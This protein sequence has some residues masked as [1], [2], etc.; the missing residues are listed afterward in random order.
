MRGIPFLFPFFRK[1]CTECCYIEVVRVCGDALGRRVAETKNA[2]VHGKHDGRAGHGAQQVR[3]QASVETHEAL[4][5]PDELEALHETRVLEL[6][7]VCDGCLS[8]ARARHLVRVGQDGRDKLGHARGAKVARPLDRAVP[9]R[10]GA[11]AALNLLLPAREVRLELLVQ[12]PVQRRLG[13]AQVA[14]AHALVHAA[15][16]LLAHNLPHAVVAVAVS[17]AHL[18]AAAGPL[19]DV[20]VEL[21]ARLDHPDG[22][23]GRRR[24]DARHAGGQHV[25]PRRLLA[26]VPALG[27]DALAVA[28]DVKVDGARRHHADEVGPEALEERLGALGALHGAQNVQRVAQVVK[29]SRERI[30][31]RLRLHGL[32]GAQLGLVNVGLESCL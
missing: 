30:A 9:R 20:L 22:V 25:H 17:S 29:G 24:R 28:V 23:R 11:P 13:D 6:A 21:H 26:V 32:R 3:R 15:D 4:L 8:Q 27:E 16:A 7:P 10:L 31:R 19:R 2:L 1:V 14:R 5:L 18:G 12:H